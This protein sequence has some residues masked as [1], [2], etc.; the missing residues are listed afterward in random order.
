MHEPLR[1]RAAAAGSFVLHP[2]Y[3]TPNQ[4]ENDTRAMAAWYQSLLRLCNVSVHSR[5]SPR[6][7][8]RTRSR[9]LHEAR[10]AFR[11]DKVSRQKLLPVTLVERLFRL[12]H[13]DTCGKSE[14]RS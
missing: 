7:A 14:V 9:A 11:E 2:L 4:D 10:L 8:C 1:Q 13:G 5:F 12:L 3:S 6:Y